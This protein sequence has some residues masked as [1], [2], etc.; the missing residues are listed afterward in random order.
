MPPTPPHG[1][2]NLLAGVSDKHQTGS[3]LGEGGINVSLLPFL[4]IISV[5][6]DKILSF[7]LG[8]WGQTK[9]LLFSNAKRQNTTPSPKGLCAT[10]YSDSPDTIAVS[11]FQKL[12]CIT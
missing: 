6:L 2:R 5:L 10:P 9:S 4:F 11:T 12:L 8:Q 1:L 3:I 7:R